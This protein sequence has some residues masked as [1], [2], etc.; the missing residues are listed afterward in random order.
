VFVGDKQRL[1]VWIYDG[2]VVHTRRE[3]PIDDDFLARRLVKEKRITAKSMEQALARAQQSK[4]PIGKTL[5]QMGEIT[6]PILN[7]V[8]RTQ[9]I[10]RFFVAR[11]WNGE[12]AINP[13][14]EP[15]LDAGLVPVNGRA[16]ISSLL[17][18][19]LRV[20]PLEDVEKA[21]GP[22]MDRAMSVDLKRLD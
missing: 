4:Q 5:V 15:K 6:Q 3:P 16:M 20:T 1:I 7:S 10:D 14:A 8:I 11:S 12:M 17:V 2:Q 19:Q 21:L 18:E 13:W 22:L 9:A